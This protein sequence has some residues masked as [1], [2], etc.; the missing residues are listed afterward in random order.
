MDA[1]FP[2]WAERGVGPGGLFRETLNLDHTPADT[3]T[4]RVRVQAR[5]TY[6]FTE[7]LR[8]GWRPDMAR[9]RIELGL[10]VLTG[11]ARRPD[12]LVGRTLRADGTGWADDTADLYDIA[13]T[14]LALAEAGAALGG[15]GAVRASANA[16]LDSVDRQMRDRTNGGYAETLPP[17]PMRLQ[18]PHMHLLEAC[19]ALH[20]ADPDTPYLAR[21]GEIISLFETR[22]TAG[23]GGLLGERFTTGWQEPTGRDA[24]IVEPGHQFEWVW[25]LHTYAA[26]AGLPV[27]DAATRL[28]TFGISSLDQ[29]GRAC[30]EVTRGATAEDGSRRTWPQTEALKAHLAMF[31]STRDDRFA[32][33]ACQSFDV[34][35]DEFLTPDGGW[36]DHYS[37]KGEVLVRDMPASTGYHVVL[38]FSE[39]MRIMRA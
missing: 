28:Y 17:P 32:D 9:D 38:A 35:M 31:E 30:Q 1:C 10:G 18:N 22:F 2:L 27:P 3:D 7:A 29:D 12:G 26:A 16:L 14:L 5:Q 19:L 11:L 15:T 21:A 39:L 13:F 8:L 24:E 37:A 33:A 25:L 23:P 36:I 20:R 4:T 34:L 6:V